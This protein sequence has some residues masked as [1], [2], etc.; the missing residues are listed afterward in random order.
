MMTLKEMNSALERISL[1]SFVKELDVN[2]HSFNRYSGVGRDYTLYVRIGQHSE[3]RDVYKP[4]HSSALTNSVF[5]LPVDEDEFRRHIATAIL[6]GVAHETFEQVSEGG[7]V[8]CAPHRY[9][10]GSTQDTQQWLFLLDSL[11]AVVDEYAE[12]VAVVV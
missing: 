6:M 10:G 3:H 1:P 8:M 2:A 12:R 4:G 9:E 7:R 11:G 5:D